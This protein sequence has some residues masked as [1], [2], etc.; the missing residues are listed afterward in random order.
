MNETKKRNLFY[1][2]VAAVIAVV[3][4]FAG[5]GTGYGVGKGADPAPDANAETEA[6]GGMV[7]SGLEEGTDGGTENHISL[8][9][10]EI[11]REEYDEYGITPIAETAYTVTATVSGNGLTTNQKNVTWGTAVFKNPSSQWASGKTISDYI[12]VSKS[13]NRLTLSCLQPFG[14]QIV[15]PCTS[16][17]NLAVSREL[18][19]D[20]EPKLCANLSIWTGTSD[21]KKYVIYNDDV[22]DLGNNS[23][24]SK[25]LISNFAWYEH[26]YFDVKPV[27]TIG[28]V[29]SNLIP[30]PLHD[31]ASISMT[32]RQ[33]VKNVLTT[34]GYNTNDC[35]IFYPEKKGLYDSN[36]PV[37]S[38]G[39]DAL[40]VVFGSQA[41]QHQSGGLVFYINQIPY[42]D[43]YY[44]RMIDLTF[45]VHYGTAS[46]T[47]VYNIQMNLSTF[48][49]YTSYVE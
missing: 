30:D 34:N 15:I 37:T 10:V 20:Y 11:P 21:Y 41:I 48:N 7:I 19:I 44:T 17:Y 45:D 46:T 16:S 33:D 13:G 35:G 47:F 38:L 27:L 43:H 23:N 14:E 36:Y 31:S 39:D 6:S 32:I 4:F 40:A 42:F 2:L 12:T 26:Y 25:T 3:F 1:V 28:T 29:E 22:L 9:S 5:F 8:T 49:N 18:T 24:Q